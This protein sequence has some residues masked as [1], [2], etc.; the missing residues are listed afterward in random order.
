MFGYQA[1]SK[2]EMLAQNP[3]RVFELR[4]QA[5]TLLRDHAASH[6]D[7][8]VLWRD[9]AAQLFDTSRRCDDFLESSALSDSE[10]RRYAARVNAWVA[11][12]S[13]LRARWTREH[14]AGTLPPSDDDLRQIVERTRRLSVTPAAQPPS[15]R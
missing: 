2:V 6:A 8:D 1:L 13:E 15:S 10:R 12:L 4:D 11:E 5:L 3:V 7:R 14:R 9:F